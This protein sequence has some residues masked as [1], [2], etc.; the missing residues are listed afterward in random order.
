MS[1][2]YNEIM[3]E[4][5]KEYEE[6]KFTYELGHHVRCGIRSSQV[7]ALVGFLVK[8]GILIPDEKGKDPR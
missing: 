7:R 4:L 6:N 1:F 5:E 8:K 2:K 3:N